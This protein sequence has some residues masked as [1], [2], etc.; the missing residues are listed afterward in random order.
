MIGTVYSTTCIHGK[1]LADCQKCYD[2]ED[3]DLDSDDGTGPA[4]WILELDDLP[5]HQASFGEEIQIAEAEGI[6]AIIEGEERS[7]W[8]QWLS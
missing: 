4:P 1:D 7:W 3:F 6:D 5:V 8:T 2:P